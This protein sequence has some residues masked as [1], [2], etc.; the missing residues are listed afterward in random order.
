LAELLVNILKWIYDHNV[1]KRIPGGPEPFLLLDGHESR[2]T[3]VFVDYITDPE[4]IWHVNLGVPHATSYWQVGD[5][6]EQK[7]HFKGMLGLAKK[8]LVS[9][10]I[11]HNLLILLNSE[12]IIP[13]ISIAW[14]Y[15]SA[16]KQNKTKGYRC[17]RM[18]PT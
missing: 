10:K 9:F 16:N 15:S 7:G 3:A 1:Y 6:S 18:V 4:H 8:D 5:S 12:N 14:K 13:L 2:L 11:R 17:P